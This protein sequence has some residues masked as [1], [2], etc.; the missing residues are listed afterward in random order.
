LPTDLGRR[1]IPKDFETELCPSVI[2]TD[3]GNSIGFLRF[4]GSEN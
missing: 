1:Y 2:I 3:I 4:S